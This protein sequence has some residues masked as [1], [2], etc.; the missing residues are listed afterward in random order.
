MSVGQGCFTFT[1][2]SFAFYIVRSSRFRN[3]KN[4]IVVAEKLFILVFKHNFY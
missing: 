4:V 2:R 3:F 1:P